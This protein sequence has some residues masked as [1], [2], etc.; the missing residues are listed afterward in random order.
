[1]ADGERVERAQRLAVGLD[2]FDAEARKHCLAVERAAEVG[3][4]DA[5][6]RPHGASEAF[7]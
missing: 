3:G 1:L 5:E 4:D 7:R 6:H 2:Q